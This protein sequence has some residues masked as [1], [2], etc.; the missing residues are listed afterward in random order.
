[1]AYKEYK[2]CEPWFMQVYEAY[3]TC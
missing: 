1:M 2:I 3:K